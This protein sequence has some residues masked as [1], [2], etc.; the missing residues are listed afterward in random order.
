MIVDLLRNDLGRVCTLDC[1]ARARADGRRVLPTVHQLISTVTGVLESARTP[2]ECVRA[3]FPGGSMTGAPKL[4]TMGIIDDIERVARGVYSGAIGYFGLDG[5]VDLSIVIRTVVMR[6]GATTIGAGGAIVMQSDPEEEFDEILLKA[7]APMAADRAGRLWPRGARLV[8]RRAR[9][10]R[11]DGRGGMSG[12]PL[13]GRRAG[14]CRGRRVGVYV[15]PTRTCPRGAA[16]AGELLAELGGAA[17]ARRQWRRPRASSLT[18]VS[19]GAA[20]GAGRR[21]VLG[22]PAGSE[23]EAVGE[24]RGRPIVGVLGASWQSAIHVPGPLCADPGPL[25]APLLA[26]RRRRRR[27]YSRRC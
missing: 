20:R 22:D 9:A 8:H 5:C 16:A 14:P 3:C 12:A 19:R 7:R 6:P 13:R 25:G 21:C 11:L 4:R 27:S 1:V 17:L 15:A 2:V 10:P 26:R 18:I 24:R 23:A